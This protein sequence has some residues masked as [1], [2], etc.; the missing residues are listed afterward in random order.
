MVLSLPL[1][2]CQE[3]NLN[4]KTIRDVIGVYYMNRAWL[5]RQKARA[6]CAAFR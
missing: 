2:Y 3:A 1:S 5:D 4:W 6:T